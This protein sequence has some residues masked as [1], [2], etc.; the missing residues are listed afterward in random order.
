MEND[1]DRASQTANSTSRL[2]RGASS[3]RPLAYASGVV[4]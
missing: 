1:F 2:L 4:L 3:S